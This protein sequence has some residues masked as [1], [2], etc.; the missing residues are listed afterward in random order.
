MS[1]HRGDII[2]FEAES[3]LKELYP[4]KYMI[5]GPKSTDKAY[6]H[7]KLLYDEKLIDANCSYFLIDLTTGIAMPFPRTV[8]YD[9]VYNHG[10]F[11]S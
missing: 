6:L 2:S 10:R 1:L 7:I 4:N 11:S 9:E 3:N 8:T 5:A